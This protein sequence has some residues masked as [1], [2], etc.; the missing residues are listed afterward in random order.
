M[1][2]VVYDLDG[3]IIKFNTFRCWL[4]IS[5]LISIVFLRVFFLFYFL[6]FVYLRKERVLNRITFK[7]AVLKLQVNSIFWNTIGNL[8]GKLLAVLFVRKEL[9][10]L[11]SLVERCLA[12]AAPSIYILP[13]SKQLKVFNHVISSHFSDSGEFIETLNNEKKRFVMATFSSSPDIFY[14]DHYD[15]I[16]L[17]KAC[18]YTYLVS[19]NKLTI[20]VFSQEMKKECY[21]IVK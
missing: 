17:A 2:K 6:K 14:T 4:I 16:P 12:T 10:Q 5:L 7:A 9:I 8:Y 13:F 1:K 21:S 3:T 19:P 18:K 15:D 20:D 11:D